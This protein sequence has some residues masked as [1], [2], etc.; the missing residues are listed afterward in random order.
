M[1]A[2]TWHGRRD[3]RVEEVPDPTIKEA[4]DAIIKI[5]WTGLCGSDLHLYETLGPFM[6]PGD[7]V[8]HEPMGIVQEVGPDVTNLKTGDRV[9]VPFN[10]CC[11]S[12]WMCEQQLYSQCET[13]QNHE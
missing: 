9:V 12:C 11:G 13:T 5:T 2:V 6:T 8:G 4:D 3:M 10:V 1:K 7:V